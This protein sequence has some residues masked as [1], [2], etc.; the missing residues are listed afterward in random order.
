M[1]CSLRRYDSPCGYGLNSSRVFLWMFCLF[2]A[3]WKRVSLYDTMVPWKHLFHLQNVSSFN[4]DRRKESLVE[5]ARVCVCVFQLPIDS[6]STSLMCTR[7]YFNSQFPWDSLK[8]ACK[9]ALVLP[10]LLL[11]LLPLG[12]HPLVAFPYGCAMFVFLSEAF[13]RVRNSRWEV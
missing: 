13:F 4:Q 1:F 2:L 5:V 10:Y 8:T 12:F 11:R 7:E 9:F 3:V 6:M